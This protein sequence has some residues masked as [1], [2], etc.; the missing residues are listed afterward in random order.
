M[1]DDRVV[2]V[3]ELGRV[4]VAGLGEDVTPVLVAEGAAPWWQV[5]GRP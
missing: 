5:V 2:F 1:G 4:A 3:D